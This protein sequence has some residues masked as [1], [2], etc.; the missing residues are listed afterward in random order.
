MAERFAQTL[1]AHNLNAFAALFAEDYINHQAS[2]A[3]TPPK[4][5]T[6]KGG[7]RRLLRRPAHGLAGLESHHPAVAR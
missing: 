2:A 7:D 5:V 4:G 3:A 6:P 1:T